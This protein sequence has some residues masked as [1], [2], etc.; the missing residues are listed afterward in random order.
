MAA[1]NRFSIAVGAIDEASPI[2]NKVKSALGGLNKPIGEAQSSFKR[3]S[4]SPA[5]D[6]IGK[7]IASIGKGAQD[8]VGWLSALVPG[9]G[10]IAAIGSGA[11][12]ANFE[13]DWTNRGASIGRVS[14][15][16]GLNT[17]SLQLW[18]GA[19]RQAMVSAAGADSALGT[20]GATM[21]SAVFGRENAAL[22][23]MA[24]LGIDVHR[25][26]EG[27]VDLDDAMMQLS[28]TFDATRAA[29]GVEAAENLVQQF[30]L[31][32]LIPLLLKGEDG[33]K[34]YREA[35]QKTNAVMSPEAI[36]AA[37][38]LY[39]K[40]T[41][42]EG[43]VEG[44]G[45]ALGTSLAPALGW[46]ADNLTAAA[47]AWSEYLSS[48]L[49]I[50]AKMKFMA[51]A[52]PGASGTPAATPYSGGGG[53]MTDALRDR[54]LTLAPLPESQPTGAGVGTGGAVDIRVHFDQAPPGTRVITQSSGNVN[55]SARVE[56]AMPNSGP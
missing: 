22:G 31:G 37:S 46:V 8:S 11:G 19:A 42:L 43:A 15:Q 34:R 12:I 13:R 14:A 21:N 35:W 30:G 48:R 25:T 52:P 29:H 55:A 17:T 51:G 54:G 40:L 56:H 2:F 16:I 24:Q 53:N 10:T 45:N 4:D 27:A 3:L 50:N 9:L 23:A 36:D 6:S 5:F 7:S 33:I 38:G 39:G 1:D 47:S 18:E 20:L 49:G 32:E 44:T 26:K 28:K 41:L